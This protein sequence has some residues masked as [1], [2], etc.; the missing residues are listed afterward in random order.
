MKISIVTVCYNSAKTI[1]DTIES[2][3]SQTY[4][5]VEY[6]IVDGASTD[7]TIEI[8]DSYRNQV[9]K[10]ISEPDHG[11]YDAMNKGIAAATGDVVGLLNSDDVY[12]HKDVLT[13]VVSSFSE[14]SSADIIF[15]DVVFASPDNMNR[16]VRYYRSSHFRPWKLRFG[17]MPPHP[18][19]FVRREVYEKYGLY[20]LNYRIASDYEIFVRWMLLNKLRYHY[21][22][23]VLVRMRTSG[24]STSGWKSSVLIT[25]EI[26]RACRDNGVYTNLPLI[27]TKVP[28]KLVEL[29]R[30]PV[31]SGV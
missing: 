12:E 2:V 16:V 29:W 30:R 13:D 8:V 1:R 18:A 5:D 4:A 3:L 24:V 14:R 11:I 31:G 22:D 10:F 15:G 21:L 27:L 17:W 23:A 7:G 20:S 6:I 9:S 25:K 28:F 26:V 19:T